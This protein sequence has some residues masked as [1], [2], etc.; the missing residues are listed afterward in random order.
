MGDPITNAGSFL[1]TTL[2]GLY[3]LIVMLR[4]L[5]Q[6][7]RVDPYNQISQFILKATN[8]VLQPLRRVIPGVG[9]IDW[10]CIVL[11]LGLKLIETA[12]VII[13]LGGSPAFIGMLVISIAGLLSLF[14]NVFLFSIIIQVVLSWVSPGAYNP[15]TSIIYSITEPLLRP[16]RNMLP[17]MG[18]LDLSPLLVLIGIQ[19][20]NILFVD[21]LTKTG[22]SLL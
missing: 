18:G 8:P 10:S 6:T 12:L 19:L 17:A 21:P 15:M 14:L 7:L 2:F 11:L 20:V 5:F 1:V 16:V 9:G 13:M 4:L 22:W 3:L